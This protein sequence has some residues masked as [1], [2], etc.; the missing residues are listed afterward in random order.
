LKQG[1]TVF[2]ANGDDDELGDGDVGDLFETSTDVGEGVGE[3]CPLPD[4]DEG[5]D[6]RQHNIDSDT[7]KSRPQLQH[8]G[9]RSTLP[10]WLLTDYADVR[11]RLASEI[12]G[13]PSHKPTCYDRG[14]FIDGSPFAFFNAKNKFQVHPELF[15]KPTYFVWIPHLFTQRIPCPDCLS[16]KR[17][18]P[19]G[20]HPFLTP[21]GWPKSPRRVVDLDRLIYVI[22]HRYYCANCQKS[23][24]SWSPGLLSAL[25]RSLAMQFTFHLTYRSGLSD[26]VVSLMRG[27]FLQGIGPVPFANMIRTNHIRRYEQLH[28]QYLEMLYERQNGPLHFLG[29]HKPFS[30]FDDHNGYAGFIPTGRYFRDFYV[31]YIGFHA[32]EIN[33]YTAMLSAKFLQ[34]DHSFKVRIVQIH[35]N[36]MANTILDP[37]TSGKAQWCFCFYGTSHR[38]E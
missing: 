29:K 31:K 36:D 21:N 33:Q 22:G 11:E 8:K 4:D 27:C 23:Y 1:T 37:E 38:R 16:H 7:R 34:I 19:K 3:F 24:Q 12:R 9:E 20:T 15:Y 5:E 6:P 26:N 25:P 28:L 32:Q 35:D 14:S 13:N 30:A 18:T 17:K 10:S 2:N